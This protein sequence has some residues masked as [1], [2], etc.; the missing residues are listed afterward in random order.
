MQRFY[1]WG[2]LSCS[3][4]AKNRWIPAIQE[5]RLGE[6]AGIASRELPKAQEWAE[7][8]AI[9]KAY[10]SYDELLA[11]AEIDAIYVGLP[12]SLHCTWVTQAL[13]AGKHVLCD[14]PLGINSKE[15][16]HM[17]EAAET[18]NRL[19]VEGFMYQFHPQ[20]LAIRK[21]L[22][23]NKIGVIKSI[24]LHFGIYYD[25]PGNYRNKKEMGG[26]ALLDLGCYCVDLLRRL[27]SQV[28]TSV[29]A[30]QSLNSEGTDWSTSAIL[31]YG[32]GMTASFDC[33]L[34]CK[35]DQGLLISGTMGHI[36]TNW[37]IS[38]RDNTV[39]Q[40][41]TT[42]KPQRIEYPLQPLYRLCIDNFHEQVGTGKYIPS[43]ARDSVKCLEVIDSIFEAAESGKTVFLS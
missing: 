29:Q 23:E 21:W 13:Q 42:Y 24:R 39:L 26:G 12:N 8:C 20:Y 10:G 18:S 2:I 43:V 6:V 11:D 22:D 19:L 41:V 17:A 7:A 5:S 37:P 36:S 34:G 15:A 35:M 28:P 9:P 3:R 1:R 16:L 14:K 32:D 27:T 33:S 25:V 38:P 4:V 40:L 31:T 30:A